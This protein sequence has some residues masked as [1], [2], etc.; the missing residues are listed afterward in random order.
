MQVGRIDC[1]DD[2]TLA[3]GI[4]WP[5]QC[6]ID[7]PGVDAARHQLQDSLNQLAFDGVELPVRDA[8]STVTQMDRQEIASLNC[9][10]PAADLPTSLA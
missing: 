5:Q 10:D 8:L 2:W 1:L 9:S 7:V 3:Q 6:V 4:V